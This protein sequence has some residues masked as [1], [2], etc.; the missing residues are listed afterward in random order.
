MRN[1]EERDP[2][3]V[4]NDVYMAFIK[5]ENLDAM[6]GKSPLMIRNHARE[7]WTVVKSASLINKCLLVTQGD[8]SLWLT[9][10]GWE[11]R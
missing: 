6:L 5:R 8:L 9:W 11:S 2:V 4:D 7:S 3:C 1:L 10:L